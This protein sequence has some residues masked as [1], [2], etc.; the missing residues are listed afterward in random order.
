LGAA[1]RTRNHQLIECHRLLL[2]LDPDVGR[3]FRHGSLGITP[4]DHY[5][6]QPD[7]ARANADNSETAK[8]VCEGTLLL[9]HHLDLCA[10]QWLQRASVYDRTG[11]HAGLLRE[12]WLGQ[13]TECKQSQPGNPTNEG[14]E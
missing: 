3:A 13:P 10:G 6:A 1:G 2:E 12:A 11:H 4:T 5:Y 8:G 9:P 14:P 7:W